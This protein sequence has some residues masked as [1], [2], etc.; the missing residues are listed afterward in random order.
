MTRS[1]GPKL[2]SHRAATVLLTLLMLVSTM[3]ATA[4]VVPSAAERSGPS[5]AG[6]AR[7]VAGVVEVT[8]SGGV[9]RAKPVRDAMAPMLVRVTQFDPERFRVEYLGLVSGEY[10][11]AELI[12]RDDGRPAAGLGVIPVRIQTQ[13]PPNHGTD[14]FGLEV[15]SLGFSA[16]YRTLLVLGAAAWLLIP[17]AAITRR[18]LNR[19]RADGTKAIVPDPTAR[20]LLIGLVEAART[21]D[22]T[23][24]ERGRLELLLL[25][26]LREDSGTAAEDEN[27]SSPPALARAIAELRSDARTEPLVR[28]VEAW[29]HA[30]K[31]GTGSDRGVA[32]ITALDDYGRGSIANAE[33]RP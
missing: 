31:S 2:R 12:E 7:G 32:A 4:Q 26:A 18:L 13:L 10:N 8:Y 27:A 25:R 5:A 9:L 23:L 28:G 16:H 20:E 14:V 22:L 1:T 15:P 11:L 30:A 6:S 21:R 33:A 3:H 24:A 17:A 29:L 19:P